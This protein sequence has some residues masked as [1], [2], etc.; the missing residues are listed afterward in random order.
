MRSPILAVV[1]VCL[2]AIIFSSA[3]SAQA[4]DKRN[5]GIENIQ[6]YSDGTI[7]RSDAAVRVFRSIYPCP[8][9]GEI[10]GACD[11]WQVDHVIPLASGGCDDVV[12]NLQWLPKVIKTGKKETCSK[13]RWERL[14]YSNKQVTKEEFPGCYE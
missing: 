4:Y 13:D 9:T 2:T 12:E 11:G 6:R 3:E 5:C 14:V 1:L 10:L 7:K 8:A